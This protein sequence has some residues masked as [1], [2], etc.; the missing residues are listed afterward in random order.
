M[1][2]TTRIN[3]KIPEQQPPKGLGKNKND[4]ATLMRI[5][6]EI[7]QGTDHHK[8]SLCATSSIKVPWSSPTIKGVNG[9]VR[10][11]GAVLC[12]SRLCPLCASIRSKEQEQELEE[13]IMYLVPK[14]YKLFFITKTK[15][16]MLDFNASYL[17]NKDG[18]RKLNKYS[19]NQKKNNGIETIRYSIFEETYSKEPVKVG[20]GKNIRYITTS[21]SHVHSLYAFHP[22]TCKREI[23]RYLKGVVRTWRD[24]MKNHG[25]RVSKQGIDVKLIDDS[26]LS[27]TKVS[28][29]LSRII[30][31]KTNLHKEMSQSQNKVGKG[32]SF[33]QLMMDIDQHGREC[34][35]KA[36]RDTVDAYYRKHRVF[37]SRNWK[38]HLQLAKEHHKNRLEELSRNYVDRLSMDYDYIE[39]IKSRSNTEYSFMDNL[40]KYSENDKPITY[41]IEFPHDMYDYLGQNRSTIPRI[42]KAVSIISSGGQSPVSI[43]MM[44]A[45]IN[46]RP[47]YS[48]DLMKKDKTLDNIIK[49]IHEE[50]QI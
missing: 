28:Q 15:S 5:Q 11:T 49:M 47:N 36:Y 40:S 31:D 43:V 18:I 33:T 19:N 32:R 30:S 48:N 10:V 37:K 42:M 20:K 34:D 29:D 50:I 4:L 9:M 13:L 41:E 25:S 14:G 16:T 27:H 38:Q 6:G 12:R 21:N 45:F 35:L 26:F 3:S 46:K 17:A 44:E 7:A 23:K 2:N 39:M 8:M 1:P 22:E 24:A